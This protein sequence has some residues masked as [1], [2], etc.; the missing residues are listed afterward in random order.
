MKKIVT[1][2]GARP[3]FVKAS[4]VS[5]ALNT[6]TSIQ[7]VLVHTGQHYDQLMSDVFF[8]D[9]NLQKPAYQLEVGSHSQGKQ[10]GRMLE[11]IEEVLLK[12]KPDGVLVYGDTN[13]TLAGALAAVK[14]NLPIAHVEAG[15]RSYNRRMPE[16]INRVLTDHVSTIHYCSSDISVR[17][18]E[19]EGISSSGEIPRTMLNVGDVMLDAVIRFSEAAEEKSKILDKIFSPFV[20]VTI[21][22]AENT[23]DPEKLNTIFQTLFDLA[24][25]GHRFILPLHPR[26]RK[27]LRNSVFSPSENFMCIP[28]VSYL[29]MLKLEK[30]AKGIITDSGGV[31]KE[32]YFFKIPTLTLRDHTEWIETL[33]CG[34]NRLSP[35]E[36]ASMRQAF[37]KML[38]V[39]N[40]DYKN[41]YGDGQASQHIA[42]HLEQF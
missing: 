18:L 12:E 6:L 34:I 10:T 23:D 14:L 5:H 25:E 20:L 42:R 38:S 9:L 24:E 4:V 28:P 15:M 11:A 16:E 26:T 41:A 19:A 17:N 40:L 29:D 8:Q 30:H 32:A 27:A 33:E 21:H 2:V 37:E 22:R 13:S 3:Q 36:G 39:R 35:I 1:I 31:Q 7:E